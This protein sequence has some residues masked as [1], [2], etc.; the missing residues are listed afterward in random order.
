M[1]STTGVDFVQVRNFLRHLNETSYG[2]AP[3]C[4]PVGTGVLFIVGKVAEARK[5]SLIA[6]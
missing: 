3:I 4:C 6:W 5:G 2:L 1:E